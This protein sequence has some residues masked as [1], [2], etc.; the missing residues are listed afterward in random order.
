[1]ASLRRGYIWRAHYRQ[2]ADVALEQYETLL[3]TYPEN[4]SLTR[5][6][7]RF[8]EANNLANASAN[9]TRKRLP[10]HPATTAGRWFW[11]NRCLRC[12][13]I[14][15]PWRRWIKLFMCGLTGDLFLAKADLEMRLLRFDAALKTYQRLYEASYHDSQ[16]LASQAA[17]QAR[18]A[19]F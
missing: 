1:V 13:T 14:R 10:I 17:L 7:S 12:A 3:N 2:A 15:K 9:F 19:F 11:P 4:E 5:E 6:V 8:A 18:L 16:Y